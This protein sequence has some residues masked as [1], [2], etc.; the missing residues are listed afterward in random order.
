MS[1]IEHPCD[2]CRW[3]FLDDDDPR[4]D[5]LCGECAPSKWESKTE[6]QILAGMKE[7]IR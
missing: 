3:R 1:D 5:E 2:S 7:G 4:F 6:S